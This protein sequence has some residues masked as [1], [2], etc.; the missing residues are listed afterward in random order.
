MALPPVKFVKIKR[1][2]RGM[3]TNGVRSKTFNFGFPLDVWTAK[4]MILTLQSLE[5]VEVKL[6]LI[7]PWIE[8]SDVFLVRVPYAENAEKRKLPRRR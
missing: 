1:L 3:S 4:K 2:E 7:L 6:S 8:K 5:E